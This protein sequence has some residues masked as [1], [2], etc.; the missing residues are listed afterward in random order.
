MK[1]IFLQPFGRNLFLIVVSESF[2]ARQQKPL[3]HLL[4]DKVHTRCRRPRS[5]NTGSAPMQETQECTLSRKK[6]LDAWCRFLLEMY[7]HPQKHYK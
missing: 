3:V 4:S 6:R 5:G 1:F 2:R 7:Q